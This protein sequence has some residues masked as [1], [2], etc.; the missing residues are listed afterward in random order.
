MTEL[1]A[2][3]FIWNKVC[4]GVTNT[5]RECMTGSVLQA[6]T[7]DSRHGGEVH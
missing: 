2:A 1:L 4:T 6:F 3:P 7:A 5:E